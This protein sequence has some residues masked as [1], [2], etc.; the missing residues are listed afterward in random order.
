M[1]EQKQKLPRAGY[2]YLMLSQ[3]DFKCYLKVLGAILSSKDELDSSFI[4]RLVHT[5]VK[6]FEKHLLD[7]NAI[8]EYRFID[9]EKELAAYTVVP[10]TEY[11]Y[12]VSKKELN[13]FFVNAI[14]KYFH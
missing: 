3:N 1:I 11:T 12:V 10:F 4:D 8:K 14:D 2:L 9:L 5:L 7:A 6:H 13:A